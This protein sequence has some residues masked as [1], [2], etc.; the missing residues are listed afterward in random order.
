MSEATSI[1]ETV[2]GYQSFRGHQRAAIGELIEGRDALVLMPTGG[3]KSIIYQI[4]SLVR[5][6]VGIVVS[7]LIALMQDQVQALHL[8]GVKAAYLNSILSREEADDIERDLL[9]G[10]I[11]L[12]YV[13][14]ERL[15]MDR[16][17]N[18]LDR[19]QVALFAIDEAH[20]VSQW[21]HDFRP[22]YLGLN[23]LAQRYPD[24][25]RVA[26]PATADAVT[27]REMRTRLS[28]EKA[29]G[30]VSSFDRPN[31][32]YEVV[33]KD[34][35][36]RQLLDFYER[37][38]K[39]DAGIVY[40]LSRRSV[41]STATWLQGKGV[42]ALPYH[43]GLDSDTRARHQ[44]RFLKEE[45]LVMVAT[46]AF[47]MG[48]DKPDVRFVAHLDVPKSLE[49]YYQETGRAGRDGQPASAFMT[50]GLNDVVTV[51]RLV[52]SGDAPDEVKRVESRK[53]DALLGYCEAA[54]C[55]R[56]ALLA[57]FGEET[58][59]ECGNCDVCSNPPETYDATVEA[60][61]ALSA[62][63]RTGGRFGAQHLINILRGRDKERIRKW[64]HDALPTFGVGS[65]LSENEWRSVLRQLVARGDLV[66]D[67]AG[68]GSLQLGK[69]AAAVL[70]GGTVV[71]MRRATEVRP[72]APG[73][74]KKAQATPL[75]QEDA[76]LFEQLRRTRSRIA[77]EQ[78]VPAYVVFHD[79]TLR[80]LVREQ[81]Q[82]L[83]EL[84][85]IPGVGAAKLERYG[86]QFLEAIRAFQQ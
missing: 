9:E 49:G 85:R 81:P 2:F 74:S 29:R 4:A 53:L 31:I 3:G 57:Y 64:N 75:A 21:G 77:K 33:D 35:A 28:L 40:C 24:V 13:A 46:I 23:V 83:D 56:Q 84:A 66:P 32:R 65:D 63:A 59:G 36:K 70:R 68:H 19:T 8:L 14:P 51:R 67:D 26:L 22:E 76:P 48:I 41:E 34:D 72:A 82:S 52:M 7:P 69:S 50:Y 44:E 5:P 60:Q 10:R 17:L 80:A 11:D 18:L 37:N 79:A 42:N 47:G 30:F 78:G 55:R 20:C 62:A 58:G 45:G 1:L 43:A 16:T 15:L 54:T 61:K 27:R 86:E 38:H 39:G 73:F 71:R 6:G 25:P 12:L